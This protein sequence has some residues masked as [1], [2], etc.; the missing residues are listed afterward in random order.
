MSQVEFAGL[1]NV[2]LVDEQKRSDFTKN[3]VKIGAVG[4]VVFAI[5][6][7][8]Q[9]NKEEPQNIL[10]QEDN[11]NNDDNKILA[12]SLHK[13]DSPPVV[14]SGEGLPKVPIT[15]NN[16]YI[17]PFNVNYRNPQ[18]PS[19]MIPN[20]YTH[21]GL[22]IHDFFDASQSTPYETQHNAVQTGVFPELLDE[23]LYGQYD[24][25]MGVGETDTIHGLIPH[26]E[27]DW[28]IHYPT[29]ESCIRESGTMDNFWDNIPEMTGGHLQLQPHLQY[30]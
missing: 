29:P 19:G 1:D 2:G 18:A 12:R 4:L 21:V 16:S 25:F 14:I 27:I 23:S 24:N 3:I 10:L 30:D 26:S 6:R 13:S 20:R 15:N 11:N 7:L 17:P 22:D 5:Y 9:N 28:S 8:M